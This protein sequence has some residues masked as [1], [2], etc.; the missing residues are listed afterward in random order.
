MV[1]S[2]LFWLL[3]DDD[4][5]ASSWWAIDIESSF[6][7]RPTKDKEVAEK[8]DVKR[9]PSAKS[10]VPPRWMDLADLNECI[11]EAR[12]WATKIL[13]TML[14]LA[15]NVLGSHP[16]QKMLLPFFE[17]RHDT[18]LLHE[19]NKNSVIDLCHVLLNRL[20]VNVFYD[21]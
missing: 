18:S 11:E 10:L 4:P 20:D 14:Y 9:A 12:V 13:Q 8:K 2:V 7:S 5:Q 15:E 19:K 1:K 3:I 17:V 16:R 21:T 6:R